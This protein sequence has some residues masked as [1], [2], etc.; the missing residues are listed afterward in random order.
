M[1]LNNMMNNQMVMHLNNVGDGYAIEYY[2]Y[3]HSTWMVMALNNVFVLYFAQTIIERKRGNTG[4]M[5]A[6]SW[7]LLCIH[8]KGFQVITIIK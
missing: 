5:A 1:H 8:L 4:K 2:G 7:Q 3:N 6:I